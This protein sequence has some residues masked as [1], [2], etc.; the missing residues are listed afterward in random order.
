MVKTSAEALLGILNDILDFSKI[1]AGKLCLDSIAFHLRD[2]IGATLKALALRAHEKGLEL[3]SRVQPEVPDALIGDPGRLRQ[4]LVNLVGNAIKFCAQG[5]VVVDVQLATETGAQ[6]QGDDATVVLHVAVHDTGIGI[7]RDKQR[8]IFEPFTQADGSTTRQYGGTGLG[9]TISKQLVELMGGQLWVESVVGQGSTFHFTARFGFQDDGANQHAPGVAIQLH[10]W[11][12]LIVDDNAT[13]RRHLHELLSH[14]GMRPI[15]VDSGQAALA[16]LAQARDLDATFPLVL[17]DAMMP[18]MDGFTLAAQIKQNPTLVGTTIILLTSGGQRGDAARCR[19]LGIAAYLTKPVTQAELWDAMVMT[20]GAITSTPAAAVI[21]RHTVQEQRQHLHVLLAEDN[22]VNQK[23]VMRMLEKWGHTVTVVS[24][25][26]EALT[27][28]AQQ[29][30]DLVLMDVQMPEM[31][32][33]EATA[34]IRAQECVSGT[35][36]PIIAMTANAMQ[37]DAERCLAA[38]TDAYIAKP[39]RLEDL[40]TAINQLLLPEARTTSEQ[41]KESVREKSH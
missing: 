34:A 10:D 13:N 37:G 30:F 9:L 14:W 19:D 31:D 12:V 3:T 1:E 38:G 41:H 23:L 20:L 39:M 24:T 11:P 5:E 40:Y 16:T 33:L 2:N 8:L 7:P 35:H 29:S 4:I 15:S 32:G 18:E 36:V 25:G 22:V 6:A 27:A 28:L 21:T 26:Q 17:L